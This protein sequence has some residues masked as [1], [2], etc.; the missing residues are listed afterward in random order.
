MFDKGLFGGMFDFN[1][2]GKLD[3][4]EKA[5]EF[6]FFMAAPVMLGASLVR[7]I[8]FFGSGVGMTANELVLLLVGTL[9]SFLV[10]IVV[11]RFLMSFVKKHSFALFGWYRILL[12]AFV[13][14]F[15]L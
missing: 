8:K 12:G 9:V 6:S 5:A 2:D 4:F 7:G 13:L 14:L 11:I 15:L 1:G 10:S 3:S